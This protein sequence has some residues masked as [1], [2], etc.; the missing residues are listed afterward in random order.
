MLPKKYMNGVDYDPFEGL[1]GVFA[2]PH[3]KQ[4]HSWRYVCSYSDGKRH[5]ARIFE[6]LAKYGQPEARGDWDL[7]HVVEGQHFAD[8]D[9][10]G[11][12]GVMYQEE[13]PVVLIHKPEHHTYNQL[14]H[15]TETDELFRDQLPSALL[16][17]SKSAQTAAMDPAQRGTLERRVQQLALL[18]QQAYAGDFVLQRISRNV[19]DDALQVLSKC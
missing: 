11:R 2:T 6:L 7:H 1:P 15:I 17:R 18:Y 16:L 19:F 12:L 4:T 13:L 9:F 10:G 14:L 8:V 5:K 3:Y